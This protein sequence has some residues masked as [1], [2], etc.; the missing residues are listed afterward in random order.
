[1]P[2]PPSRPRHGTQTLRK[3]LAAVALG[4]AAMTASGCS[5]AA[6][7]A[8]PQASTAA[9]AAAQS[10]RSGTAGMQPSDSAVP[11]TATATPTATPTAQ[12]AVKKLVEGFPLAAVPLM[13]KAQ[14]QVSSTE[15]AGPVSLA[16]M[17]A[18][19]TAGSAEVLD[20][21]TKAFTA[22]GFTAQPGDAVDGV[23]LKTFVRTGGQ[24]VATVSVIEEAGTATFTV[25]ATLL[26]AAFK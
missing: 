22:Q 19:I 21:Y 16:S 23:P 4:A 2:N 7:P 26:P 11:A 6:E 25:G 1:M 14:I 18:S 12:T 8:D 5:G 3:A 17:T 24:E 13:E 9:P 15:K 20:Y 10:T